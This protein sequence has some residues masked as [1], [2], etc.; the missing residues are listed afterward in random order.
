MQM[1]LNAGSYELDPELG[2]KAR[3]RGLLRSLLGSIPNPDAVL[4]AVYVV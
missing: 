2:A 3:P 4:S 1:M